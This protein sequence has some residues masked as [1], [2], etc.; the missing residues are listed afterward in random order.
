MLLIKYSALK[1][2]SNSLFA[3]CKG[4]WTWQESGK[5]L[6]V[7]SGIPGFK[8]RNTAQGIR[9]LTNDWNPESSTWDPE[10]TAWNPE[11][12]TGLDS[13]TWGDLF[14]LSWPKVIQKRLYSWPQSRTPNEQQQ[15]QQTKDVINA[16]LI[17]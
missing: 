15:H 4:I 5:F 17:I 10:S 14:L 11:S 9:N 13:F 7:G 8:I 12:K 6:L 3:S 16:I 2:L 1:T